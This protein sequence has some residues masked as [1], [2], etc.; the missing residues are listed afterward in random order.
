[1]PR[2]TAVLVCHGFTAQPKTVDHIAGYLERA[3][4]A[5]V[6]MDLLG[7]RRGSMNEPK[8]AVMIPLIDVR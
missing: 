2:D 4:F 7:Y 8:P 6:A 5:Y 1:M 3:G